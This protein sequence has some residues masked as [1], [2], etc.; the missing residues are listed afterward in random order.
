MQVGGV[1]HRQQ[2]GDGAVAGGDFLQQQGVGDGVDF[3]AV[4]FGGGGG[5][6]EAELAHFPDDLGLD[7]AGLLARSGVRGEAVGGEFA[8]HVDDQAVA[9]EAGVVGH[10]VPPIRPPGAVAAGS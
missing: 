7:P 9:A 2:G 5:A 4:P 10:G 1:V 3:R 8:G 6:E